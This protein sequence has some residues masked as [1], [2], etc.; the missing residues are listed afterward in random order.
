MKYCSSLPPQH[1]RVTHLF[2]QEEHFWFIPSLT[3]ESEERVVYCCLFHLIFLKIQAPCI[4]LGIYHTSIYD[5]E[6]FYY[7]SEEALG[8][9]NVLHKVWQGI[10]TYPIA[11][12]EPYPPL[13]SF[14]SG[15]PMSWVMSC[16]LSGSASQYSIG[17]LIPK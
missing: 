2:A 6:K 4:L 7:E 5:T 15:A 13:L 16:C 11:W 1:F 17:P 12:L 8:S 14:S 9:K 10:K 3:R